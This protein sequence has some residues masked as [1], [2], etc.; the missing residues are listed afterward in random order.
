MRTLVAL[1]IALCAIACTTNTQTQQPPSDAGAADDPGEGEGEGQAEGEVD[2]EDEGA[3]EAEDGD[4][5]GGGSGPSLPDGAGCNTAADCSSGEVCEGMGCGEGEGR[6][7][8]ADRICTRDLALY[9]GCD[10]AEFQ[11]SGTCPGDRYAHRGPCEPKLGLGE[12]CTVGAQ[13]ESGL[14][15]GD[16][17]EGCGGSATGQCSDQPCTADLAPYCSCNGFDFSASGSCPNRQFAK[18]GTCDGGPAN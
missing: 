12:A 13:C 10:G 18:R 16:G 3:P 1:S 9:C 4:E 2:G 11:S 15:V 6:C 5:T 7:A 17:L 8:P 14:C